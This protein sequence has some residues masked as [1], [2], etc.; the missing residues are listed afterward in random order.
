MTP[1]PE[2]LDLGDRV[3][4]LGI[5]LATVC[6][7]D[8]DRIG[9]WVDAGLHA[10]HP[11]MHLWRVGGPLQSGDLVQVLDTAGTEALRSARGLV[12]G[13]FSAAL[14]VYLFSDEV[15]GFPALIAATDLRR[16]RR[17]HVE[18]PQ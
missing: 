17:H 3:S 15:L 16:L 14:V 12:V 1:P 18:V 6:E 8:G 9:V 7:I 13:K 2:V 5:W 11:A 4:V 10:H